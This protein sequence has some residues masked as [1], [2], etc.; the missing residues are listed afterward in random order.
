MEKIIHVNNDRFLG[1]INVS[2]EWEIHFRMVQ[3]KCGDLTLSRF[4]AAILSDSWISPE[5]GMMK[6]TD[7]IWRASHAARLILTRTFRVPHQ[8]VSSLERFSCQ[9]HN[10]NPTFQVT[11]EKRWSSLS[12]FNTYDEMENKRREQWTQA[13]ILTQTDFYLHLRCDRR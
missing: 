7:S 12:A 9:S 10:D 6:W 3:F 8:S 2:F 11:G 1:W 13:I 4:L 5:G